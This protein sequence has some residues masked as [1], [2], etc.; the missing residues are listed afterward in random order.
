M[1]EEEVA[2]KS[3]NIHV[4]TAAVKSRE[5]ISAE[6]VRGQKIENILQQTYIYVTMKIGLD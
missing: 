4:T 6:P 2:A 5:D 3:R 1:R